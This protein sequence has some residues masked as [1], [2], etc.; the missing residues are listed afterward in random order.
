[1]PE[2]E[3]ALETA[4]PAQAFIRDNAFAPPRGRS[5]LAPLFLRI[6]LRSKAN[7]FKEWPERE[8][9]RYVGSVY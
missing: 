9:C 7:T 4:R 6:L 2:V 8:K 3:S 5:L 1:M